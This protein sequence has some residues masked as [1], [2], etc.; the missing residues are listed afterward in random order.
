MHNFKIKYII[1]WRVFCLETL[2]M[3]TFNI[4]NSVM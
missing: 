3:F 1:Y 4:L 2:K